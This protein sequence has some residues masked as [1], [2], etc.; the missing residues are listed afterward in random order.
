MLQMAISSRFE[1][2]TMGASSALAGRTGSKYSRR[3][4]I[5]P[6]VARRRNTDSWRYICPVDLMSAS[7]LTS[8]AAVSGSASLV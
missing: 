6:L 3:C 7:A 8:A 2:P 4:A 5:L 1:R